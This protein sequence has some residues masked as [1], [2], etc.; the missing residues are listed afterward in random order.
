MIFSDKFIC[1]APVTI[2]H[3]T[4]AAQGYVAPLAREMSQ[5]CVYWSADRP[6][7]Q[8]YVRPSAG[9]E[10]DPLV[11]ARMAGIV[12]LEPPTTPSFRGTVSVVI[13]TRDRP[14]QLVRCLTSFKGQ[15][16]RPD[17]VLVVDNASQTDATRQ[18][19]KTVGVDYLREDRPGLDIARNSGAKAA[20]G[21]IVVYTDDDVVLH[22]RWLE[23]L[24]N[25]FQ[26]SEIWA[27]T[28]LILPGSLQSEAEC[29]F[30]SQW[31]FGRGFGRKDFGNDFYMEH[32]SR[33][34]PTWVIG[35]GANMAFR[36]EAFERVGYFDER[37]D[38]GAAG[39]SGDSEFWYRILHKGGVCRYEPSA[40]VYHYHRNPMEALGRQI[41]A[42][43][44][45]HTAAL[46]VQFERTGDWGNLK[47]LFLTL[48]VWYV[49]KIAQRLQHGPT[50]QTLLLEQELK[51]CFEG[52]IYYLKAPKPRRCR[53][54]DGLAFH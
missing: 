16:R 33:G 49:R 11:L 23:R 39:C 15:S 31:G 32:R 30:E 45:G 52:M 36:R 37:L 46:F 53:V 29:L 44:S 7:G 13:C 40:V 9:D 25:A 51:G 6:I 26:S 21:D 22:D 41:R 54:K 1:H 3:M 38:V 2:R 42:Y 27:A 20:R 19:A 35:A 50:E 14:D 18:A 24:V 43:M 8:L 17:Q 10:I 48:P 5:L 34:C 47:R 12:A 4:L 28:G